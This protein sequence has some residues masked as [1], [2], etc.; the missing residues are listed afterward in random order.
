MI[1]Y[2]PGDSIDP[3]L[4]GLTRKIFAF[5]AKVA[6]EERMAELKG[7][8]ATECLRLLAKNTMLKLR[9]CDWQQIYDRIRTD[10]EAFARYY[11]AGRIQIENDT[12]MNVFC[13]IMLNDDFYALLR[14][15]QSES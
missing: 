5:Y 9:D 8:G 3:E 2:Q 15:N 1:H 7:S 4:L 14:G 12:Y 6:K 11:P 13:A 10:P